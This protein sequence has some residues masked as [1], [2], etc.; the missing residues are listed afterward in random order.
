ML[1]PPPYT[2]PA[3]P[4]SATSALKSAMSSS[5]PRRAPDLPSPGPSALDA[6][7]VP[8]PAGLCFSGFWEN[9]ARESSASSALS[10][11]SSS[12]KAAAMPP[13]D[14]WTGLG[15][16]LGGVPAEIGAPPFTNLGP[17]C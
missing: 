8:E 17:S 6:L 13:P 14:C 2:G 12:P 11:L 9:E 1:V 3:L 15:R 7:L 5:M 4:A 16:G 10:L